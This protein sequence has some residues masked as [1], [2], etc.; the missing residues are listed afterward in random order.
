LNRQ[1]ERYAREGVPISLSTLADQVGA[2]CMAL[3]PLLQQLQ[4]HVLAVERLH[5]D[6]T[7]MPVLA[8]GKTDI[9]RCWTYVRDDRP[10][11]GQDSPAAMFC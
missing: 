9:G 11:G 4:A 5:S 3:A 1:A 6:D 8:K 7:T 2:A 10:F